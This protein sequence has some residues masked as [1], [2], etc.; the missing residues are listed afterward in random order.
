MME[1]RKYVFLNTTDGKQFLTNYTIASLE[2]KLPESFVRVSRSSIVNSLL[3]KEL[4]KYFS[5]KYLI[6]MRD[7]KASKIET[8]SAYGDNLKRLME[9]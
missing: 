8:G 1:F 9:I 6:I 3:I 2:E 5:G 4:Q 7:A